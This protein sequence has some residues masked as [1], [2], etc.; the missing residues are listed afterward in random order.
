MAFEVTPFATDFPGSEGSGRAFILGENKAIDT[1]QQN[2]KSTLEDIAKKKAAATKDLAELDVDM[3]KVW[4][5][6][7]PYFNQQLSGFR[8]KA[9]QFYKWS[10]SNPNMYGSEEYFK[11]YTD[12]KKE[13]D[14]LRLEAD[15]SGVQKGIWDKANSTYITNQD[16]YDEES[17]INQAN[18]RGMNIYQRQAALS[19]ASDPQTGQVQPVNLL[20]PS[21]AVDYNKMIKTGA[22][23]IGDYAKQTDNGVNKIFQSNPYFDEKGA[24]TKVGGKALEQAR[25]LLNKDQEFEKWI[26][27]QEKNARMAG[28]QAPPREQILEEAAMDMIKAKDTQWKQDVMTPKESKSKDEIK[29]SGN[30]LTIGNTVVSYSR[31]KNPIKG[32]PGAMTETIYFDQ[33]DGNG[34]VVEKNDRDWVVEQYDDATKTMSKQNVIGRLRSVTT[35][36]KTAALVGKIITNDI[37]AIK[38]SDPTKYAAEKKK[39]NADAAYKPIFEVTIPLQGTDNYLNLMNQYGVSPWQVRYL[40]TGSYDVTDTEFTGSGITTPPDQQRQAGTEAVKKVEPPKPAEKKQAAATST[41]SSASAAQKKIVDEV[42]R[43][44]PGKFKS[45]DEAYTYLLNYAGGKK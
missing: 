18:F 17:L 10:Y 24:M 34:N 4:D 20:T 44:N 13:S 2:L 41:Y 27:L 6:D 5:A 43:K 9:S 35:D 42:M 25:V 16:K 26:K 15:M 7:T 3:S 36:P 12:L 28:K 33:I 22:D 21:I 11:R 38:Y 29:K 30:K 8:D 32:A 1:F 40:M 45:Q 14:K 23:N 19:G 39:M 31:Y 37:E